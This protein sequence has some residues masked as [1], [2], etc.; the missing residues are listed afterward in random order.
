MK[1]RNASK[2]Y[3]STLPITAPS[4][5]VYVLR[6][7][8]TKVYLSVRGDHTWKYAR[9]LHIIGKGYAVE[10][11]KFLVARNIHK[12]KTIQKAEEFYAKTILILE[13]EAHDEN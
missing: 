3:N 4:H 5:D 7:Y 11:D 9:L 12:F 10:V 13:A 2:K 1:T 6:T 8:E